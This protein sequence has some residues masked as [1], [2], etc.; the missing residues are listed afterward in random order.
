MAEA[1]AT[2]MVMPPNGPLPTSAL[3]AHSIS[4]FVPLRDNISESMATIFPDFEN[5]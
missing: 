1:E 4:L 2:A 5:L 3:P